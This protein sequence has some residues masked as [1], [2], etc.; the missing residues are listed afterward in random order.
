ML[1]MVK[2][3]NKVKLKE[4][5]KKHKKNI[6]IYNVFIWIVFILLIFSYYSQS[7]NVVSYQEL[8]RQVNNRCGNNITLPQEG[9]SNFAEVISPP[10]SP[11]PFI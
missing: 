11:L 9:H 5:H 3:E 6:I 2:N 7:K 10:I 4:F 1:F 8:Q